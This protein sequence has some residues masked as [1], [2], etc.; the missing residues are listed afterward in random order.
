MLNGFWG[1]SKSGGNRD[2]ESDQL[3]VGRKGGN[4]MTGQ[5]INHVIDVFR[6]VESYS[7]RGGKRGM[8]DT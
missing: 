8:R 2:S 6:R 4:K 7:G 3:A 1:E 5:V